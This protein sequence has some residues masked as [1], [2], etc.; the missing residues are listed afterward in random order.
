MRCD[1]IVVIN[2]VIIFY[3]LN[4]YPQERKSQTSTSIASPSH[5]TM[6]PRLRTASQLVVHPPSLWRSNDCTAPSPR[7]FSTSYRRETRQRRIMFSWLRNQ[8]AN[9]EKPLPGS[10]NYLGAY[11]P[12]GLLKRAL[13][14]NT[15]SGEESKSARSEA[16]SNSQA[17]DTEKNVPPERDGDFIPFPLNKFFRSESVVDE[18]MREDIWSKIM[19]DGQSVKAVSVELGVEMS[20]VGAI[21]RLK[22]VEKDWLRKVSHSVFLFLVPRETLMMISTNSISL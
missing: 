3:T 9:F 16:K 10:T 18:Q 5:K 2:H 15:E 22:E 21:V 8:G 4:L 19:K 1:S 14:A 12:Q 20:R 13:E 6:P 11:N 7:L 17:Q